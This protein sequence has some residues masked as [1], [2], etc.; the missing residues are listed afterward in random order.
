MS[1]CVCVCTHVYHIISHVQNLDPDHGEEVMKDLPE[2]RQHA[3][4]MQGTEED[5]LPPSSTIAISDEAMLEKVVS[6]LSETDYKMSLK[7]DSVTKSQLS[8]A[9]PGME[10][11]NYVSIVPKLHDKL[12]VFGLILSQHISHKLSAKQQAKVVVVAGTKPHSEE[13]H[14]ELTSL[15]PKA[16]IELFTGAKEESMTTKLCLSQPTILVC[17]AGKLYHELQSKAVHL[18]IIT[19]LVMDD[20][21]M[22]LMNTSL[23]DVLQYYLHSKINYKL[24]GPH[25]VGVMCF[26]GEGFV[27]LTIDD[28]QERLL[29]MC[30]IIN[31]NGGM[32]TP[33]NYP[34]GDSPKDTRFSVTTFKFRDSKRDF[35]AH[36][37]VE[38]GHLE[39]RCEFTCPFEKWSPAYSS[40]VQAHRDT[41]L[42][43]STADTISSHLPTV[44]YLELLLCCAKAM[45]VCR[46]FGCEDAVQVLRRHSISES[47]SRPPDSP[48]KDAEHALV[49]LQAELQKIVTRKNPIFESVAEKLTSQFSQSPL[50]KGIIFVDS[51]KEGRFLCEEIKKIPY[52]V[53]PSIIDHVYVIRD[54][55]M[56]SSMETDSSPPPTHELNIL[57]NFIR[58][59]C[60]LLIIPFPIETDK[61]KL[62]L[63]SCNFLLRLCQVANTTTMLETEYILTSFASSATKPCSKLL[64]DLQLV[65]LEAVLKD[66]PFKKQTDKMV[67]RR[68]RTLV[69][70]YLAQTRIPLVPPRKN[71]NKSPAEKFILKCKKC[72]TFACK[73]KDIYTLFAD[74]GQ[75]YVVPN[76]D[77]RFRFMTKVYRSQHKT[78]K[79]IS[80]QH[81]VLCSNCDSRWGTICYFP[82][83]RCVLPVIKSKYFVFEMDQKLHLVKIWQH[84]PFY[85]P[86]ITACTFFRSRGTS[87]PSESE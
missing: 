7:W 41:L 5:I 57:K 12:V 35:V 82:T 61:E 1:V 17:T 58:A 26:P 24:N 4:N 75:F 54:S 11:K 55:N 59:E 66:H 34:Q 19:L 3:D 13:L 64:E 79:R 29:N 73:G 69:Q 80:R 46:E 67:S 36:L 52:H 74:G 27:A 77:F 38:M 6:S 40:F 50:S 76:R 8:L 84:V 43:V 60:R 85:V 70:D 62:Q 78:I 10:E 51:L 45:N 32:T 22:A 28:M 48:F 33:G 86:P 63:P 72:K 42:A 81:K 87:P 71:T 21:H 37:A 25:M 39:D 14:K 47:S 53:R 16:N 65:L 68:Q 2:G 49:M 31:A 30:A 18:D 44:S 15:L 9:R 20:F 56:D 23:R 83:R